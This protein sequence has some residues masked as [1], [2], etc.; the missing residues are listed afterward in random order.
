LG[1]E[2]SGIAPDRGLA[3]DQG[4]SRAIN[5][6]IQETQR[7]STPFIARVAL[8]IMGGRGDDGHQKRAE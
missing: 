6:S 2:L 4:I 3:T 1:A 5:A 7:D 8:N